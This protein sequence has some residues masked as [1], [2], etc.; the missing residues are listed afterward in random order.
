MQMEDRDR[1]V[2][3]LRTAGEPLDGPKLVQVTGLDIA[4][5]DRALWGSPDTFIWQPGHRWAL[6]PERQRASTLAAQEFHDSRD[7]P[8]IPRSPEELRALVLE[9]GVVLRI[10]RRPMD[11]DALFSVRS[12]GDAV[13]L[14]VNSTHEFY[15]EL[16]DLFDDRQPASPY[17]KALEVLFEAWALYEDGVPGG[18]AKRSVEDVRLLWGRRAIQVLKETHG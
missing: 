5:V 18:P 11:T 4:A 7:M 14:V 16:P 8:L 15:S 3:A 10:S 9:N 17:R 1:L 2:D 13:Q 12:S 6:R